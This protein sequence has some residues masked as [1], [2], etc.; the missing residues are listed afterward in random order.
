[1]S[2]NPSLSYEIHIP[3]LHVGETE[4]IALALTEAGTLL[5][6]DM[7]DGREAARALGI[8]VS[9]AV[10]VLI[11]ARQKGWI[12]ALRPE[13]LALRTKARFFLAPAFFMDALAAF[14]ETAEPP[15]V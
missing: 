13:L 14:G 8:R 6:M 5:L 11:S 12:P 10:G 7:S 3:D 15:S 4:S 2:C 1:M 9:G